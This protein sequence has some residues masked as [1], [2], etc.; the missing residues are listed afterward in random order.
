[1]VLEENR[2]AWKLPVGHE[3]GPSWVSNTQA[4]PPLGSHP[5]E[6]HEQDNRE[7]SVLARSVLGRRNPIVPDTPIGMGGG[8]P[9]VVSPVSG[10]R[11]SGRGMRPAGGNSRS[12]KK[13]N[14]IYTGEVEMMD[15][16]DK[17]SDG[18]VVKRNDRAVAEAEAEVFSPDAVPSGGASF[19]ERPESYRT[20]GHPRQMAGGYLDE[21]MGLTPAVAGAMSLAVLLER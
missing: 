17:F 8:S 12:P 2:P 10:A 16:L 11:R 14:V 6:I 15:S 20:H 9:L 21:R 5:T 3:N 4:F 19:E 7:L 13:L 18:L 1:M